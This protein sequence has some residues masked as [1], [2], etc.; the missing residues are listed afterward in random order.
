MQEIQA[1]I[2]EG[3]QFEDYFKQQRSKIARELA[4]HED[5]IYYV[6]L[7]P[8]LDQ[9]SRLKMLEK[10]GIFYFGKLYDEVLTNVK[11]WGHQSL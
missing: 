5:T 11:N 4:C 3:V 10:S 7:Q 9:A 6:C 2:S 8:G 1:L